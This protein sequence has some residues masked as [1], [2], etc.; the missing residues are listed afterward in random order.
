MAYFCGSKQYV[1][2][3][4]VNRAVAVLRSG[5]IILYPTDT[6]W[7]I[8]CD[9]T[10]AEAVAKIYGLKRSH[11]KK[12]MI[13][14]VDRIENVARYFRQ[15]PAVAWDLLEMADQPLTLILSGA[16]GV[17]PNLIPEEGTLAVR[18]PRH[19]FCQAL[20]RRLGR[21]L[22]STS[23][24]ISGEPSP[25]R[26]DDIVKEIFAG[27]DLAVDEKYKGHSTGRPSS[28]IMLGSGGEVSVIRE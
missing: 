14:L 17:A 5:G 20:A 23:A 16:V 9:A 24:N 21:P 28:I 15:V 8:G 2:Q 22:V 11:D 18:V 25:V 13:V 26:H 27:V 6:V 19:E 7:G 4:E 3:E 10:N 12:G 1:M